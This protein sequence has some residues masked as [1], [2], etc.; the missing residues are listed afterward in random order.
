MLSCLCHRFWKDLSTGSANHR[1]KK[2]QSCEGV[3]YN[4]CTCIFFYQILNVFTLCYLYYRV[5]DLPILGQATI[6][7]AK[8]LLQHFRDYRGFSQLV[9]AGSSMGGLHA[10]M[11]ASVF[12][13]DVGATAWLAPPSAV[14]VFADGL[15]SGSCNWGSLYK[16]HELQMLDK[17]LAGHAVA[18]SY[19]NLANVVVDA[20]KDRAEASEVELDPVQESKKR[21]RLFLSITDIDNF[22][23]PRRSDAVVFVY[24][25]ED[26]YIG[27]TEPQWEVRFGQV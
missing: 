25:T 5:S 26:E 21:M 4:V 19:E 22:L 7:E 3:E 6:E 11:V 1:S 13:G 16:Q 8:S 23:P 2:D 17:M 18:E 20:E 10:A 15:L 12:P 9:V 24:G 14:P 27:F